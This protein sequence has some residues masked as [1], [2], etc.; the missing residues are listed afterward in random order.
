V[1]Q[2]LHCEFSKLSI[3]HKFAKNL[4]VALHAVDHEAFECF[5][6][7]IAEVIL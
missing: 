3:R 5:L 7:D 2:V 1:Q 4:L 6:E